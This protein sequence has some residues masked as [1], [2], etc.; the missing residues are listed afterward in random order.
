MH[1]SLSLGGSSSVKTL[2]SFVVEVTLLWIR[3]GETPFGMYHLA[4]QVYQM[5][6]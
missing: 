2:D 5:H 6:I 1:Q 3:E 4:L